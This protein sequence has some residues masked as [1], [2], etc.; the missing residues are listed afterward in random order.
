MRPFKFTYLSFALIF[1]LTGCDGYSALQKSVALNNQQVSTV[2]T[3]Y[4][5]SVSQAQTLVPLITSALASG[6]LRPLATQGLLTG[7]INILPQLDTSL[8]QLHSDLLSFIQHNNADASN[9]PPRGGSLLHVITSPSAFLPSV[10]QVHYFLNST[11]GQVEQMFLVQLPNGFEGYVSI[12]WLGGEV[13][14]TQAN[15]L[16]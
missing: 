11:T 7:K 2:L 14:G 10:L 1:L 8:S 9:P 12:L 4:H 13:I 15:L 16:G 5:Q 6:N 3:R